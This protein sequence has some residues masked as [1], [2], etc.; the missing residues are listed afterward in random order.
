MQQ[1]LLLNRIRFIFSINKNADK[2][3]DAVASVVQFL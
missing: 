2:P 3:R 1:K